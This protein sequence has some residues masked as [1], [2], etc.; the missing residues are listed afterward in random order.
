MGTLP[1]LGSIPRG[2]PWAK[3]DKRNLASLAQNRECC[4]LQTERRWHSMHLRTNKRRNSPS[5]RFKNRMGCFK[6]YWVSQHQRFSSTRRRHEWKTEPE[7]CAVWSLKP[8]SHSRHSIRFSNS[9]LSRCMIVSNLLRCL[10]SRPW[11][12]KTKINVHV[13]VNHSECRANWP[14]HADTH[15]RHWRMV[16]MNYQKNIRL[17]NEASG[18][19]LYFLSGFWD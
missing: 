10:E 8:Q 17:K 5:E 18:Q 4:S 11:F 2:E 15:N 13:N 16:R 6:R 9:Y 14:K 1:V 3:E 19:R 12:I 7:C